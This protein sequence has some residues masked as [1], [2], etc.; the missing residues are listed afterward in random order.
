MGLRGER[1]VLL[2]ARREDMNK[3]LNDPSPPSR[4]GQCDTRILRTHIIK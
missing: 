2:N 1:L 3:F 4:Q